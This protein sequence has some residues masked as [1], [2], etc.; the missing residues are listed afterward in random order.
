MCIDLFDV[1]DISLR[2]DSYTSLIVHVL[3]RH[4]AVARGVFQRLTGKEVT[5]DNPRVLFRKSIP[6]GDHP[7][8]RIEAKTDS[9]EWWL[10]IE[11]KIKASEGSWQCEGYRTQCERA[12]D[13]GEC[14]GFTLVFL[15]LS[16]F[17][18]DDTGWDKLT[19]GELFKI[20]D[21]LAPENQI[22]DDE[23]VGAA[24]RAYKTRLLQYDN[25]PGTDPNHSLIEWLQAA[26]RGFVTVE[27]R[28]RELSEFLA[29]QDWEKWGGLYV[30]RGRQQCLCI[31]SKPDWITEQYPEGDALEQCFSVHFEL[32]IP[33]PYP[34]GAAEFTCHLHCETNPYMTRAEVEALGEAGAGFINFANAFKR[35]LHPLLA[36][37][38]WHPTNRWLQKAKL[39]CLLTAETPIGSF[40]DYL[41]PEFQSVEDSVTNAI[42]AARG[43]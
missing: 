14:T 21:G 19:H 8:I 11:S 37:T 23:A 22:V 40:R 32:D 35:H 42:N 36:G 41:L 39:R 24:W 16:G 18:P 20:M 43:D 3:R 25:R 4:D 13:A 10:V 28:C 34:D 33:Y 27:D 7:D 17:L 1:L 15:T 29:P 12:R 31:F 2:E 30:A 38:S 26:P 6:G 5:G 9:G